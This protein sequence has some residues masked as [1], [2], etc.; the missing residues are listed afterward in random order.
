MS[1]GSRVS[2]SA[3]L[4]STRP[5]SSLSRYPRWF[6]AFQHLI[7]ERSKVPATTTSRLAIKHGTTGTVLIIDQCRV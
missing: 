7:V 5:G 2:N 1:M 3:G 4:L 6:T